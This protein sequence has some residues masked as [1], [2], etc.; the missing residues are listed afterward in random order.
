MAAM[1]FLDLG[2]RE[3][4]LS[5][6]AR[7]A[8]IVAI[9]LADV[10]YS[11]ATGQSLS[12]ID[13]GA[14]TSAYGINASGEVTGCTPAAGS[15]AHAF[16]YSAGVMTDLG[17]LGGPT[18]C[19]YAINAG[20][21]ITG[22]ADTGAA[23]HAFLYGNGGMTDLGTV[24]AEPTSA[25]VSI[26][27]NGEV[28]GYAWPFAPF[29]PLQPPGLYGAAGLVVPPIY[30]GSVAHA[31]QYSQGVI[32]DLFPSPPGP[33]GSYFAFGINDTGQIAGDIAAGCG[34][35]CPYGTAF[36]LVGGVSTDLQDLPG[37]DGTVFLTAI[38]GINDAGQIVA[39]GMDPLAY[40]HGLI[41]TNGIPLDLGNNT[42]ALAINSSGDVVGFTLGNSA[43]GLYTAIGK[44]MSPFVYGNGAKGALNLPGAIPTGINDSGWI[45][46]NHLT[47]GHAYLLRPADISLA[48]FGLSFGSVAFGQTNPAPAYDCGACT[49]T[50]TNNTAAAI[51]VTGVAVA[52]AFAQT[53]TCAGSLAPAASCV[54]TVTFKPTVPDIELGALTVGA[55]GSQYATLL[56][57]AAII[58]AKISSS[59]TAVAINQPFTLTWSATAGANCS[60]GGDTQFNG[61]VSVSGSKTITE[62]ASQTDTFTLNC[63]EGSQSAQAQATVTVTAAKSGGGSGG[64]GS[65]G[66]V[67]VVGLL[68]VWGGRKLRA[69]P[70][71]RLTGGAS[72]G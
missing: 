51:S 35:L 57:G 32:T 10:V 48:P 5:T 9:L 12:L 3:S 70:S 61:P 22:Y 69:N 19:G 67:W 44:D 37:N 13:L 7:T 1:K 20:G 34:I 64:G 59:A 39:Y 26:N 43:I 56:R 58:T 50:L 53:N 33:V 62:T 15:A 17:T 38:T 18:S 63:T 60:A 55:A 28:V 36:T 25:G 47:L 16:L 65:L 52:G 66:L 46:A 42:E 6:R 21:Q 54:I 29:A 31:F 71:S 45:I 2:A 14:G 27:A 24:D 40:M 49:V 23:S 4:L 41:Y 68:A 8:A 30:G 11:A 72:N